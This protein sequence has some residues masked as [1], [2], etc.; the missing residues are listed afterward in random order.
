MEYGDKLAIFSASGTPV[1]R[2]G[3]AE[4]ILRS[5]AWRQVIGNFDIHRLADVSERAR[6][7][8]EGVS[9]A[10]SLSNDVVAIFDELEDM[11]AKVPLVGSISAMDVVRNSLP[12][13]GD[14]E[15]VI[16]SLDTELNEFGENVAWLTRASKRIRGKDLSSVSGNEMDALFADA[17]G[18]ARDLR[19][20]VRT[21]KD[22][23]LVGRGSVEGLENALWAGSEAPIIGDALGDF[24]RSAGRFESKLADLS[25]LMGEFELE[26][27]VLEDDIQ[28]TLESA[29][30]T[31]SGDM[32]RWLVEPNDSEWPPAD[33]ERRPSASSSR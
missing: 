13:V 9:D 14:A 19:G 24:A 2:Q 1:R 33:P 4:G 8:D 15:D 29:D 5:Y 32:K 25:S 30:R 27:E 26:L 6:R 12:G 20:S 16:R 23:V 17:S 28:D 31:F 11:K 22:L 18:A 21:A 3:L 10:R 7:L